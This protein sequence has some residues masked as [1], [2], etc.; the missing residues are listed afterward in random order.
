MVVL[1]AGG[2]FTEIYQDSVVRCAPVDRDM[3]RAMIDEVRGLRIASGYRGR[4]AGDLDALADAVVAV[5][6][7]AGCVDVSE[8]EI[9]PLL[10][11]RIG[12]GVAAL[13][14]LVVLRAKQNKVKGMVDITS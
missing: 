4:V 12:D 1:G 11:K 14:A 3:A 7:M 6:R 9:N 13:D 5:S 2:V 10:I 8:A